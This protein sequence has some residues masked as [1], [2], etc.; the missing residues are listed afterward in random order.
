[1]EQTAWYLILNPM[2][3]GGKAEKKYPQI[4]ELLTKKG[5]SFTTFKTSAAGDGEKAVTTALKDGYR[6]ILVCGGDGTLNE[7]VNGIM[8]QDLVPNQEITIGLIPIGTGNDWGRTW[9]LSRN[10]KTS[11]AILQNGKTAIQDVGL[12]K[13]DHKPDSKIWFMNVA[14]CG[15]D[16]AVAYAANKEKEKG[17]SGVLTYIK[18][19]VYTLFKYEPVECQL[20]I[21]GK[22]VSAQLFAVLVGIGKFAGNKM[23][24]VP[25]AIPNDGLF[26]ITLVHKISPWKVIR[27]F[28]KLF[29][30]KFLGLKEVSVYQGTE[31]SITSKKDVYF[32]ADGES[33]GKVPLHI[34]LVPNAI[35]VIIG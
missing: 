10:I 26:D 15:F 1:M 8:N 20:T 24:L 6:K 12:V 33:M 17:N 23:K 32:Q 34:T 9:N 7:I 22:T 27:N 2:A 21:N 25:N 18:Q 29:N 4:A 19:L 3:G 14:G 31:F 35:K 16:A 13:F 11:I 28:P 5:I 30:G